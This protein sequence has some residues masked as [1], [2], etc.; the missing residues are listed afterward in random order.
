[1]RFGCSHLDAT[2]LRFPIRRVT[3][4][5]SSQTGNQTDAMA[6]MGVDVPEFLNNGIR[7]V[8]RSLLFV[9]SRSLKEDEAPT[10]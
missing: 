10:C 6:T 7:R 3:L 8:S 2:S 4:I 5:W 1:M 9:R